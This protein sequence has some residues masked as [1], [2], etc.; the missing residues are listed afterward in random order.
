MACIHIKKSPTNKYQIGS[1]PIEDVDMPRDGR[2]RVWLVP[3][4]TAGPSR[5]CLSVGLHVWAEGEGSRQRICI[6]LVCILVLVILEMLVWDGSS[7]LVKGL[8]HGVIYII[9]TWAERQNMKHKI[10]Y[11]GRHIGGSEEIKE[12]RST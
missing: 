5:N 7:L 10:E 9:L 2:T 12:K 8:V 6:A 3:S 4:R 11:E 1:S